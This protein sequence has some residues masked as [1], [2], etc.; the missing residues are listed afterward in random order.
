MLKNLTV[1]ILCTLLLVSFSVSFGKAIPEHKL[2]RMSPN[3]YVYQEGS[4]KHNLTVVSG[5][6]NAN[7]VT[8]TIYYYDPY[9]FVQ[10]Y[11]P[12]TFPGDT[13]ICEFEL[14]PDPAYLLKVRGIYAEGGGLANFFVTDGPTNDEG[15]RVRGFG[16]NIL[17]N[18]EWN[19]V[20]SPAG[21]FVWEELDF[22][23]TGPD[24][25][26]LP[27]SSDPD[28]SKRPFFVIGYVCS[29]T[30]A[31]QGGGEPDIGVDYNETYEYGGP[32][33]SHSTFTYSGAGWYGVLWGSTYWGQ[34][35]FEVVVQ[36]Y[37][38]TSPFINSVSQLN[39]TWKTS[40]F[41]QIAAELVDVDGEITEEWM[42]YQKNSEN[43]DSVNATS[44]TDNMYY[45]DIPGTYAAGDTIT[46]WV[47]VTDNDGKTVLAAK[48]SFMV[49]GPQY[50][51]A[52]ILVV[53]NGLLGE[54]ANLDTF[55]TPLLNAVIQD[56]ME[57]QYETWDVDEHSGID[58]SVIDYTS[59]EHALC[60]G[61]S[62]NALPVEE[63]GL[64]EDFVK[65][66]KNIFVASNDYL[67]AQTESNVE[68]TFS[69]GDFIYDIF[70]VG[71]ATN[72]PDT[73]GVS[74]GDDILIGVSGDPIS[75]IWFQTPLLLNF[76][77]VNELNWNDYASAASGL[78]EAA[79]VFLGVTSLKGNGTRN[80][81]SYGGKGVYL[82][83]N[84]S[85]LVD[86]T[87]GT[88]T[89]LGD[90]NQLLNNVLEWFTSGGVGIDD[91]PYNQI[92]SYELKTNYPNPFNPITTIEYSLMDKS[93]VTLIVYNALG[94]KVK[95]LV[96]DMQSP[97]K[98]QVKWD[99]TNDG[100]YPV[101]SGVYIYKLTAGDFTKAH[102][103]ILMK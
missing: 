4:L 41:K 37:K 72:D 33:R 12:Y 22:T 8:D 66:G 20:G 86:T 25:I 73:G 54:E 47:K 1:F 88:F 70:G 29:G 57:A 64:W 19:V 69:E 46:Y 32:L 82:T 59:F 48:K 51:T 35:V 10:D 2:M 5:V 43:P 81:S 67:F 93:Q 45:Y 9:W 61:F 90:A 36:Y 30:E 34:W 58:K 97:R 50:P 76:T 15:N 92:Y 83:F 60:L 3:K 78:T 63:Y 53:F 77:L 87:G 52:P 18:K 96:N 38:G 24:T 62:M 65:A 49:L 84:L 79:T 103:M 16:P 56:S 14:I 13:V 94:E 26:F 80:V 100:G 42:F 55:W 71:T 6:E 102:K 40:E 44:M 21:Q 68:L 28:P 7:G 27:W 91:S 89:I 75:E 95:T 99:G 74:V 17:A 23:P 85:T 98:Y 31:V 39:D 101:S 11:S